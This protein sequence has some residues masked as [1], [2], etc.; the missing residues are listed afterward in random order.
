MLFRNVISGTQLPPRSTEQFLA[1]RISMMPSKLARRSK[2]PGLSP[3]WV[4]DGAFS[5]GVLPPTRGTLFATLAGDSVGALGAGERLCPQ[6]SQTPAVASRR[7]WLL[8]LPHD[9]QVMTGMD[10]PPMDA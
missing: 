9:G 4:V 3:P 7:S 8:D 6:N 1:R 5:G 10:H 2:K